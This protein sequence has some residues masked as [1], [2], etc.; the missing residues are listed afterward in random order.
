VVCVCV[1]DL[2]WTRIEA[3]VRTDTPQRRA[4]CIWTRNTEEYQTSDGSQELSYHQR[5]DHLW[6]LPVPRE[7]ESEHLEGSALPCRPGGAVEFR[8]EGYSVWMVL[9]IFGRCCRRQLNSS[10][11]KR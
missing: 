9:P 7:M 3:I 5:H 11:T 2:Q 8:D 10:R 4:V 1:E 6:P